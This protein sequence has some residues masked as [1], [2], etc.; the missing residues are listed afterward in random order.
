MSIWAPLRVFWRSFSSDATLPHGFKAT[1]VSCGIKKKA[2]KL[3]LAVVCSAAPCAAAGVFTTN[4]F[5][6]AP[7]L[8]SQQQL[9]KHANSIHGVLINAGRANACTGDQGIADANRSIEIMSRLGVPNALVMSTGVI[10]PFLEMNKIEKGAQ[11]AVAQLSDSLASWKSASEAIMTTD[12]FPKLLH[13]SF[14][15]PE[16]QRAA[17]RFNMA[18]FCKGAGMIHPNMATMLALIATDAKVSPAALSTALRYAAQRS[19]NA[20]SID[21]DTSTNDT[22]TVLANG[23]HPSLKDD[24][25]LTEQSD[26]F[27]FFR[28]ALTSFAGE[29]A[30]LIVRDGEGAT[31]FI[32]IT[33]K[34][35]KSEADAHR[36]ASSIAKSPLVKTAMYGKDANWGRI[37]CAAGY[38]GIPLQ[39]EKVNLWFLDLEHSS[40]E[41]K[42]M[43]LV[44]SGQPL[45]LDED[46]AKKLLSKRDIGIVLRLG[47]GQAS[48]TYWTC[49]FSEDYIK[50]NADYRS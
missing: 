16:S 35:A 9:A 24:A 5:R 3:D 8:V 36:I 31:K 29:L 46:A 49:D 39:P 14:S 15:F 50:I 17:R 11:A 19:F 7:V 34:E 27:V 41:L 33:V 23:Q 10:G 42:G 2:G 28:D 40:D 38:A 1:G 37:L 30:R 47:L 6:A 22:F 26:D 48:A 12:T 20:I 45:P 32:A 21:G 25:P 44:K 43:Q 18:G 4:Q 13:R